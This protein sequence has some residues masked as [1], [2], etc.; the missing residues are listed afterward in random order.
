MYTGSIETRM[1]SYFFYFV[2]NLLYSHSLSLLFDFHSNHSPSNLVFCL[3]ILICPFH[4]IFSFHSN[5]SVSSNVFFFS[6]S[7][8]QNRSG[9]ASF[10]YCSYSIG[11]LCS[12]VILRIQWC[13]LG[14]TFARKSRMRIGSWMLTNSVFTSS[15]D[16][17][18]GWSLTFFDT[19]EKMCRAYCCN[20]FMAR[21]MHV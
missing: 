12:R 9:F 1:I 14:K 8:P 7:P 15:Q 10:S 18:R 6:S 3:V 20:Y 21:N 19:A 5:K 11:I 4:F 13:S 2:F 16:S 17:V